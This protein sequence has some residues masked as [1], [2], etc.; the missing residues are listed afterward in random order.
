MGYHF[1]KVGSNLLALDIMLLFKSKSGKTI[2][3]SWK[4]YDL[5]AGLISDYVTAEPV[6]KRW[7]PQFS[8]SEIGI[9]VDS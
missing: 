8:S 7:S 1:P 2:G 5:G 9:V 3:Y 6:Q 4:I